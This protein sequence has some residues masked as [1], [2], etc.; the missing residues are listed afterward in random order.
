[1]TNNENESNILKRGQIKGIL[2]DN[3]MKILPE[4]TFLSYKNNTY[5]FQRLRQFDKF[6]ISEVFH[7]LFT[8]NSKI[9]DC[10]VAS[11]LDKSLITLNTYDTGFINPHINLI[12][13]KTDKMSHPY[14]EAYYFHD[15]TVINAIKKSE[16][17]LNDFK[18][19]GVPFLNK[20]YERLLNSK[21]VNLGLN[22]IS[23]LNIDKIV[24][25]ENIENY[26]TNNNYSISAIENP[27]YI[28]L[29]TQLLAIPNETNEERKKIPKLAYD[30]LKLYCST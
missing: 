17:I 11:R 16:Q 6:V 14:H 9:F 2:I 12:V 5:Y 4:F 23:N 8:M 10:G 21:I 13:I 19:Y 29:K 30:L 7:I 27:L 20:Q 1:M 22:F 25:N 18:E 24:L 28:E 15:G 3:F 26:L